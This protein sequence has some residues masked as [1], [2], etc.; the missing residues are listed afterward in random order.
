MYMYVTCAAH[1]P[2]INELFHWS[3]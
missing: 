2:F 3:L 1:M